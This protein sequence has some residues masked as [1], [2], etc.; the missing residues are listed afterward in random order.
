[1]VKRR[2]APGLFLLVISLSGLTGCINE[3]PQLG[4]IHHRLMPCQ[5]TPNCVVSRKDTPDTHKIA[6]FSYRGEQD[7]AYR[8]LLNLLNQRK[9]AIVV[10][11]EHAHYIRADFRT[12]VLGFIDDVEFFFK[13]PGTI[14]I[15][16]ASRIGYYDFGANRKRME[17]LRKLFEQRIITSPETDEHPEI[18]TD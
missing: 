3:R 15:R 10:E 8:Q 9:D 6:P 2:L 18:Q 4:I 14:Q 13:Q 12:P 7:D 1:M 5:D 11:M 17:A 16:S